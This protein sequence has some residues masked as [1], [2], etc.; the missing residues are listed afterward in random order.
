MRTQETQDRRSST[1]FGPFKHYL[2]RGTPDPDVDHVPV[3]PDTD[4]GAP[5]KMPPDQPGLPEEDQPD[6]PPTGDPSP[7]DPPLLVS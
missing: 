2:T 6:P 4:R 5:V 1:A 7:N 3:P